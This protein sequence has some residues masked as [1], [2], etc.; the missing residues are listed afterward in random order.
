MTLNLISAVE[1]ASNQ[2]KV[3][4][5]N[6]AKGWLD[7]PVSFLEAMAL[8]GTEISEAWGSVE[9][10]SYPLQGCSVTEATASELADVY[11]R[12][13]DDCSRFGVDLGREVEQSLAEFTRFPLVPVMWGFAVYCLAL[14]S[15]LRDIIEA[16]RS[17]GLGA[18]GTVVHEDIARAFG[19]LYL[20][21]QATCD[22]HDIDLPKAFEAKM[23]VNWE[24]PYRHGNKIA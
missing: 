19:L 14:F 16:Y 1:H 10:W 3:H 4:E 6:S 9:L 22:D 7:K 24:R 23:A 12:L 11:I 18:D 21:L 2:L 20:Q 8:L 13:L 15:R 5:C 17:H